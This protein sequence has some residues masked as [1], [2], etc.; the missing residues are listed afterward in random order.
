M[1]RAWALCTKNPYLRNVMREY[2]NIPRP[3]FTPERITRLQPDEVFV[4]G[5]NQEGMHTRGAA[6]M[7]A[8]AFGD[9]W[10]QGVGLHE[11]RYVTRIGC[12]IAGFRDR[13]IAPLFAE[14]KGVPN[15][16]LPKTFAD[17]LE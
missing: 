17:A 16:C 2:N 3:D 1:K 6:R 4:F 13:E 14:A 11:Q 8:E 10:G 7:A 12:G 5:S 15:I 9:V